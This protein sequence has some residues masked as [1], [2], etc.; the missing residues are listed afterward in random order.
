MVATGLFA[1]GDLEPAEALIR[2]YLL[3]TAITSKPCACWRAS[4]WR[5]RFIFDAQVLLA[6][7][8][9]RAPDYRAARQEY[10]FVLV[11]LHRYEEARA[12]SSNCCAMSPQSALKILQAAASVGLG[13]HERAIGLYRK[14][15]VGGPG[16]CRGAPVDRPCAEDTRADAAGGRVLPPRRRV[17]PDFGDA[18]WSLANLK[19]YRFTSEELARMRSALAA[20]ATRLVDRYHLCFAIGKALEDRGEFAESFR[21]YQRGNELKR[22]ECRY[23]AELIERNTQQQIKVCTAQF[24]AGR[25]GW[26]TPGRIRYSSSVCR[27]RARR[28]SSRSW[29]RTRRSRARRN[30]PTFSRSSAACA[31][32]AGDGGSALPARARGPERGGLSQARDGVSCRHARLPQRQARHVLHRQDAEQFP[33]R[34]ACAPHAAEC[35]HHRCPAR[36]DGMLL[37]QLQAAV[38]QRPGIHLQHRGHRPLLPHLLRTRCAHWDGAARACTAC[39][40]R[41]CGG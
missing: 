38:R 22:P 9:E 26:G 32:S 35:A 6:A 19:T 15:L 27:A 12:N 7:V 36:A 37:Q 1:D 24:F 20:P 16:G 33:A 39:V 29:R 3:S 30:C 18:Y 11:E 25:Q 21:Y 34:R 17:R 28:C 13:E 10:A 8:L 23:R 40:P 41:G 4:A 14:L 5:T 31:V 2:A